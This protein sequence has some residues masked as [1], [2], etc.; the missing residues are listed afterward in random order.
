VGKWQQHPAGAALL[1]K[2]A[3]GNLSE[4]ENNGFAMAAGLDFIP[5]V[6]TRPVPDRPKGIADLARSL[7]DLATR[8][9]RTISAWQDHVM[10]L[11]Q[12][13]NVTK[14]SVARVVSFDDESLAL[15]LTIG[16]L[17]YGAGD[18]AVTEGTSAVPQR[19]LTTLFGAAPLRDLGARAR[20][21]LHDKIS[22]LF[23]EERQ[24]FAEIID[25]ASA[26]DETSAPQLREAA[27]ALEAAR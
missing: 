3:A 23:D 27:I 20:L 15:V 13:E 14:R 12:A 1:G 6:K 18:V 26:P 5:S 9:A 2:L 10:H 16:M 11:V 19:L 7:P 8:S 25:D 24:R 17:G 22:L 4:P 21:D